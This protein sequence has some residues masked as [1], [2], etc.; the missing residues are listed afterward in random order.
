MK[1]KILG[2]GGA[3]SDGLPYNSFIID[4][5][6]LVET[7]P[8]IMNSLFREQIP[9]ENIESVYISHL[10]GDH[11]FGFPFLALRMFYEYK[12][13][14]N[15]RPLAIYL[16]SG[17][18]EYLKSL[19]EHALSKNH[20]CIE[21]MADTFKFK[22]ITGHSGFDTMG[23]SFRLYRMEH[24]LETYG[25]AVYK[26]SMA[27]FAYTADTLWCQSVEEIIG[28]GAGV[29]LLDM[30]GEPDDPKPVHMGE[31]DVANKGFSLLKS[32]TTLYGTHLKK[33]K[34]SPDERIKYPL[35][36]D[37]INTV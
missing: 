16:P 14:S 28:T 21:W 10:H 4:D 27:L 37:I 3:I 11:T 15:I 13:G 8:D 30:N 9:V 22:N 6:L 19:T 17:G 32:G 20:P 5:R 18:A 34:I 29:I 23:Y 35:P 26:N 7:P 33:N 24:T 25:F 31:R 36:G 1:I 2:N 12:R